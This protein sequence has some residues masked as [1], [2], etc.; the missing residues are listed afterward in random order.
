MK[1]TGV[2][3]IN[4]NIIRNNKGSIFKFISSKDSYF[5]KFGEIY[6]N[7]INKN[8][9]KGW[10]LHKKTKCTLSLIYGQVIFHLIDGRKKSKTY[11]REAKII[12]NEKSFK[13]L[14]IPKGIWFSVKS[15]KKNS[16]IA[17]LIEKPH[18]DKE[19]IKK[20]RVKNYFIKN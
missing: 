17:N 18:S 10:I 2:K 14:N 4:K 15:K 12:L 1:I 6:F 7:Q 8:K 3:L 9:T 20:D 16:L 11:N 19:T 5:K 13:I